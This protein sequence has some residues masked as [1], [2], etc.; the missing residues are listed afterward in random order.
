LALRP[1]PVTLVLLDL[2]RMWGARQVLGLQHLGLLSLQALMV[3]LDL[4]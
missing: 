1:V 2:V 4:E 3:E